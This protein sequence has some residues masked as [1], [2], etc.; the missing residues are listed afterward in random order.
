MFAIVLAVTALSAPIREVIIGG[1][2]STE[3]GCCQDN[4]TP[5]NNETC[6]N[7]HNTS[8]ANMND[9]RVYWNQT[10]STI[11]PN[12]KNC[13]RTNSFRM[14]WIESEKCIVFFL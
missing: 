14:C 1:C 4:I 3:Y 12:Y 11:T 10:S 8:I 13:V 5:C 2:S 6:Y 7:C 9:W